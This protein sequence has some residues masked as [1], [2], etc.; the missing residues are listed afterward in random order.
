MAVVMASGFISSRFSAVV[1]LPGVAGGGG[2][3]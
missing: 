2:S 3:G 1:M